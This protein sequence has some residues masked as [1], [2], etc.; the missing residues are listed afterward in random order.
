MITWLQTSF[1]KH[2]KIIFGSLLAVVILAFVLTIGPQSGFMDQGEQQ[3][4]SR[5][6]FGYDLNSRRDTE[7]LSTK[8]QI[9]AMLN[10]D[11]TRI[12]RNNIMDY[13]LARAAGVHLA[14]QFGITS[15]TE[16]QSKEFIASR[17]AFQDENGNFSRDR[18]TSFRDSIINSGRASMDDVNLVLLEDWRIEQVSKALGGP[19]FMLPFEALKK[20]TEDNTRWTVEAATFDFNS[21]Q[22]ETE[23]VDEELQA[24]Y[25]INPTRFEEPERI[26]VLA[27]EFTQ[28]NFIDGIQEPTDVELR[29]YFE[30]NKRRFQKT[31][32]PPAEGEEAPATPPETTY[33]EVQAEVLTAVR[34]ERARKLAEQAASNF[35]T[36]LYRQSIAK[37]SEAFDTLMA[38]LKGTANDL[39]PYTRNNPP[40]SSGIQYQALL[41]AF[42]LSEESYF[43][44]IQRTNRGAAILIYQDRLPPYV[45]AFEEARQKVLTQ[46][47]QEERRRLF[48]ERGQELSQQ[49]E[50]A[51]VTGSTFAE[52]T[53]EL[54][55]EHKS[56]DTFTGLEVPM[57]LRG[58][59]F[60]AA[61]ALLPGETTPMVFEQNKGTFVLLLNKEVPEA[62]LDSEGVKE[63]LAEMG[64]MLQMVDSWSLLAEY[65]A[66]EIKRITPDAELSA[67][68]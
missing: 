49:I 22:L 5:T 61:M 40:W 55:L 4:S 30:Q 51:L 47:V 15:P 8:A 39:A 53:A 24:F 54:G 21:F 36:R 20:Y 38:E 17:G 46:F 13:G 50:D 67:V 29:A 68:Q 7:R 64:E 44:D 11:D 65:A 45:P 14:N 43:S 63:Q 10:P 66:S 58:T 18:F 32:P 16:E 12:F 37:D 6:V 57:E 31:P 1:G 48:T 62:T 34:N 23:P 27:V 2:H 19:G 9:S 25:E 35:V 41:S 56:F 28:E 52:I 26:D 59:I 3:I 60:E 42:N 33:E